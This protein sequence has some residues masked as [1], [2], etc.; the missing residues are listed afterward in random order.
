MAKAVQAQVCG[1]TLQLPAKCSVAALQSMEPFPD[2]G[3]AAGVIPV[4]P[5]NNINATFLVLCSVPP[6]LSSWNTFVSAS[7]D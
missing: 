1:T 2:A 4:S 3:L 5:C 7:G 6:K